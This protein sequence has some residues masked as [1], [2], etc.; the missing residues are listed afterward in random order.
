MR[1]DVSE[2]V[3]ECCVGSIVEGAPEEAR[4]PCYR[5]HGC[6]RWVTPRMRADPFEHCARPTYAMVYETI[7]GHPLWGKEPI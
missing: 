1:H 2:P 7:M 4:H 3:E 5:C 6:G